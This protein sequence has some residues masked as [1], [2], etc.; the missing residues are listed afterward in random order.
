[1][2]LASCLENIKKYSIMLRRK[3]NFNYVIKVRGEKSGSLSI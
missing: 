3:G 1:M 2:I